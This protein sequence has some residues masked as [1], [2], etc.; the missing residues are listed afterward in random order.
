MS[1]DR[2]DSVNT[3]LW[4]FKPRNPF[5]IDLMD[6]LLLVD[7]DLELSAMLQTYLS[8]EGYTVETAS[9][10][11]VGLEKAL[12]GD[13]SAIVLDIMMPEL[14][15]TEVLTQ[16]RQK[17]TT[18]VIML[19]AKG[20]DLDRIIGLELGADDYLPKPCNPRELLARIKAVLRRSANQKSDNTEQ[21]TKAIGINNEHGPL[22]VLET[23]HQ[24]LYH[25]NNLELTNAEFKILC[26]LIRHINEVVRKETLY[27]EALGRA[28]TAYDR[29][30]DMHVSNIR[31]KVTALAT[32]NDDQDLI[33]NI[34]GVGYRL[35]IEA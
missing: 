18:P 10:G 25:D 21:T 32:T 27:K 24:I 30:V 13:Y 31:K 26:V 4:A 20:D 28:F 1:A 17:A 7:D 6:T 12:S 29:S 15:G 2:K 9:D 3:D 8:N 35:N 19:T 22:R 5:I 11:R 33:V 16:L 23:Q 34:R 14:N